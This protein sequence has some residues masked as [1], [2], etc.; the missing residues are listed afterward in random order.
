MHDSHGVHLTTP[1]LWTPGIL[2]FVLKG[3]RMR[4]TDSNQDMHSHTNTMPPP[5]RSMRRWLWYSLFGFLIFDGLTIIHNL[6]FTPATIN[7]LKI[8]ADINNTLGWFLGVSFCISRLPHSWWK[9]STRTAHPPLLQAAQ[10]RIPFWI[11]VVF[12][13]NAIERSAYM[14]YDMIHT[15]PVL[16]WPSIFLLLRYPF[17]FLAVSSLYRHSL[18]S[19]ARLRLALDGFLILTALITF[20]WY[21]LLGP[22]ILEVHPSALEK[23][24]AIAYPLSDMI[25]CFY[26]FQLSFRNSEPTFRLV[27]RL[28]LLG[29][30]GIV[31]ADLS[32]ISQLLLAISVLPLLQ[33]LFLC[34]GYILITLAVQALYNIANDHQ[35][36][37]N[38]APDE[39]VSSTSAF[40]LFLW[41]SLLPSACV[42]AVLLFMFIIW[43]TRGTGPLATG[44]YLAGIAL[45]VQLVVRQILV[46]YET[47]ISNQAQQRMQKELST[48]NLALTQANHRLEE[49]TQELTIAYEQ[50]RQA[51]RLKDQFLLNVNHE[52]RT[53]L[54]EMHGYLELLHYTQGTIDAKTHERYLSHALHGSEELQRL[55][56]TILDALRSEHA[57]ET[58]HKEV[59]TVNSV[60]QEVVELFDPRKRE[61]YQLNLSVP[62]ELTVHADRQ[63]LRQILANLLANAYK[64]SPSQTIIDICAQEV[65]AID[66]PPHVHIW[67]QDHGPGIP[68]DNFPFLF[69]KFFR[70]AQHQTSSIHGTGLGLYICKQLVE[71]MDGHIWVESSGIPGEGC[72]F[73]FSL[74]TLLR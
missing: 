19:I 55:V 25:L 43:S 26:L 49:Q 32:N 2:N 70:L 23:I 71:A 56:D 10:L 4:S 16:D 52:L 27:K 45:I 15:A 41:Q 37:T 22:I 61:A 63:Y 66:K 39:E 62:A 50:L 64:Y 5:R 12:S 17:L 7:S 8:F 57:R 1:S 24:E 69:S 31:I 18:S 9:K 14:Y 21:F 42:P 68:P 3:N 46:M 67:V 30:L 73:C 72:C 51:G 29:L 60:V 34:L 40:S 11:A 44:V 6:F 33:S 58:L 53:P 74:P 48:K 28:F 47:F 65:P 13:I 35:A 54:T 20:S 36:N 38:A 59:V